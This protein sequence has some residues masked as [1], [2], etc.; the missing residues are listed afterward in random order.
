M[1][2]INPLLVLGYIRTNTVQQY[3]TLS[4]DVHHQWID[5]CYEYL[6]GH[7]SD[8]VKKI[9]LHCRKNDEDKQFSCFVGPQINDLYDD[10]IFSAKIKFS[11][12]ANSLAVFHRTPNGHK[13]YLDGLGDLIDKLD[14]AHEDKQKYLNLY[15]EDEPNNQINARTSQL[16]PHSPIYVIPQSI[17][18]PITPPYALQTSANCDDSTIVLT[19]YDNVQIQS[20]SFRCCDASECSESSSEYNPETYSDIQSDQVLLQCYGYHILDIISETFTGCVYEA[21]Y[22]QITNKMHHKWDHLH[23]SLN[24]KQMDANV[25]IK[26]VM[27]G[28]VNSNNETKEALILHHLTVMNRPPQNNICNFIEFIETDKHYFLVEEYG[29]RMTLGMF[30]ERAHKYIK[31]KRLQVKE[32]RVF[33][34]YLFWQLAVHMHWMHFDMNCCHLGLN[35]NNI[36]ITN[37][38][39][40]LKSGNG[41]VSIDSKSLCVKLCDFGQCEVF[42]YDTAPEQLECVKSGLNMDYIHN[43]PEYFNGERFNPIQADSWSLGVILYRLFTGVRPYLYPDSSDEG[44][45]ALKNG[46]LMDHL[47]GMCISKQAVRLMQGLLCTETNKRMD[48]KQLLRCKWFRTYYKRLEMMIRKKTRTQ[49]VKR[50]QQQQKMRQFP[51]YRHRM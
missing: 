5:L 37:A 38:H 11:F 49:K 50:I 35:M 2:L 31:E 24:T 33:V 18:D 22:I 4:I 26:K 36:L 44:Y 15:L 40:V 47:F 10:L 39:F 41:S 23:A 20:N 51:F 3:Q 45:V 13:S 19:A 12:K 16:C 46:T 28:Q 8:H 14:D 32:W 48:T 17:T 42:A 1:S 9:R 6:N 25:A 29:T 30:A 27:K 7:S 21:Q 43:S 34:K